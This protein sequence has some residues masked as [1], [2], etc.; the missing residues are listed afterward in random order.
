MKLLTK[1]FIISFGLLLAGCAQDPSVYDL[2]SP[3][4]DSGEGK[5]SPCAKRSPIENVVV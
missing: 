5:N 4:V 1:I 3:C 2:K